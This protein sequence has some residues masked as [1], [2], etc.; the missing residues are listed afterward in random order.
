MIHKL[1]LLPLL[2]LWLACFIHSGVLGCSDC[3]DVETNG[4]VCD[5][6]TVNLCQTDHSKSWKVAVITQ[7][8]MDLYSCDG[9]EAGD[10]LLL[11]V[12]KGRLINYGKYEVVTA[13]DV[14]PIDGDEKSQCRVVFDKP[15]TMDLEK[16]HL[17]C[18]IAQRLPSFDKVSLRNKCVLT[19][20][21]QKDGL[22]G[23]LAFE[24]DN[25]VIDST[26][27]IDMTGKGFTG[28]VGGDSRGGGGYGGETFDC[29]ANALLGKGGDISNV[30]WAKNTDGI[31]GGGAGDGP[32]TRVGSKGGPGGTNAGGGGGDSTVNSDDGAAGGGGGGHFSGGGGGGGGSGCGGKDG[33]KGGSAGNIGTHAGGGG[34][35][36]CP[37][38]HGGDGGS[39]GKWPPNQAPHCYDKS[40]SGGNAGSS[41]SGGG[42]GDSCGNSYGGGGGGGGLQFGHTNFT[43]HLS[44]GGGGGGGG[45]SAFSDDPNPGGKG[46]S[47]GGLVYLQVGKL[48]LQGT[49]SVKG[50]SGQCLNRKGHRSAPGGSGAGGS[51]VIFTKKL[52][53]DPKSKISVSGGDPVKCAF[54]TGGGGGG[55]TG[56]WVVQEGQSTH[57]G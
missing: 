35:S 2:F 7:D 20:D 48:V 14:T 17:T 31:G 28:G 5:G 32:Q 29:P 55:G 13:Q 52:I 50:N 16:D 10:K 15:I 21:E 25:L 24:A 40:A 54:G 56:R 26:S 4:F 42:G 33:G 39:A 11:F 30:P 57:H 53:G 23:I 12:S 19:C 45:A 46:G 37:G 34:Q 43:T 3:T 38:G 36:S 49:I 22:G 47:G 27:K 9:L 8:T 44:Y 51:V 6:Q 1:H 18:L 41:S